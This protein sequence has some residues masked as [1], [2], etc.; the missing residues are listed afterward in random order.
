MN[1]SLPQELSTPI[2]GPVTQTIRKVYLG[3][4]HF[5]ANLVGTALAPRSLFY[6]GTLVASDSCSV[7]IIGSRNCSLDG[8]RCAF[9]LAYEL[10]LA[11][12]CIVSGLALGI[13]G[14]AHRG[15]LAARGRT[16]AVLGTGLD[17]VYP[18][19]HQELAE[20]VVSNGALLSQF[21]PSFTGYPGGGHFKKRNAIVSG[22]SQLVL[23][24][25][26]KLHSGTAD[27]IRKALAQGRKVGL[28]RSLVESQHWAAQL[29]EHHQV[30]IIREAYCVL[31]RLEM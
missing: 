27:T 21:S 4:P 13:D 8:E 12:V 2:P 26:A 23:V 10:A 16:L 18:V 29:A 15:A 7:A 22:L 9:S 11:G 3:N 20:Q 24:V 1:L 6:R 28:V 25:E 14:A 19:A 17:H 31:K 5:P 30:F